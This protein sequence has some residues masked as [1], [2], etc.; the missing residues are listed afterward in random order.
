MENIACIVVK[1]CLPRRCL[2]MAMARTTWKTILALP[3]LLLG[4]R[5]SGLA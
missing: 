1:A 4:V 5:I 2:A 3:F